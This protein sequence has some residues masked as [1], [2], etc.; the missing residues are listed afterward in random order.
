MTEDDFISRLIGPSRL[1][2]TS[3][4]ACLLAQALGCLRQQAPQ[5]TFDLAFD[6]VLSKDTLPGGNTGRQR[7]AALEAAQTRLTQPLKYETLR[8]GHR[9][10]DY[11]VLFTSLSL[12]EDTE[13]ITGEFNPHFRTYWLELAASFTPVEVASLLLLR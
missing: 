5:L 12:D 6:D 13:R 2:L 9:C 4:E 7:Y 3:V 1:V 8:Q 11:T 10:S